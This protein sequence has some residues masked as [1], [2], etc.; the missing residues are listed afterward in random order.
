MK[1][2]E[3]QFVIQSHKK[4]WNDQKWKLRQ[5]IY[6]FKAIFGRSPCNINDH[7]MRGRS[8]DNHT[9]TLR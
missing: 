7:T 6:I 1:I 8:Q 4:N 9:G 5:N 3:S 2:L